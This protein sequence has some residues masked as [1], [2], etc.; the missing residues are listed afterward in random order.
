MLIALLLGSAIYFTFTLFAAWDENE[1]YLKNEQAL[2]NQI[3]N[4]AK[5]K[6]H[7]DEYLARLI[8][9]PKF[10]ER[11]VREKLGYAEAKE[12]VFRF[13][14]NLSPTQ[15]APEVSTTNSASSADANPASATTENTVSR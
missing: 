13:D 4:L 8:S 7:K 10:Q 3:D 9:D 12:I 5:E 2:L 6:A 1:R 15:K 11:I 14:E